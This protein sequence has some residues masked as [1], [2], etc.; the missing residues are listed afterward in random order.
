MALMRASRSAR[1]LAAASCRRAVRTTPQAPSARQNTREDTAHPLNNTTIVCYSIRHD[2]YRIEM[3]RNVGESQPWPMTRLTL[4]AATE[5]SV[6][7]AG[8]HSQPPRASS[9]AACA[10]G[11]SGQYSVMRMR[12][13]ISVNSSPSGPHTHDKNES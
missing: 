11:F 13:R 1:C 4:S 9:S 7:T 2:E 5:A 12:T 3:H 10:C 8:C 6:A